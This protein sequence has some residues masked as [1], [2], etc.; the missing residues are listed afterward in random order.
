MHANPLFWSNTPESGHC[1]N[2]EW[3][4]RAMAI[5]NTLTDGLILALPMPLIWRLQLP[6]RQKIALC[7]VFLLGSL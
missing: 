7:G 1:I 2:V 3:F 4:Y 6:K 5:P